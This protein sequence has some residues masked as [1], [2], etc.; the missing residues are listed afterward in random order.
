MSVKDLATSFVKRLVTKRISRRQAFKW[1]GVAV[2]SSLLPGMS[3][4]ARAQ[5]SREEGGVAPDE[6]SGLGAYL[7]KPVS[8]LVDLDP[9]S[10]PPGQQERHRIY[11]LLL[12]ALVHHYRNG[13]KRGRSGLYPWNENREPEAWKQDP[14]SND[15]EHLG[16][17]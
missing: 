7:D 9:I 12:M 6:F 15:G 10:I 11:L 13:N 4:S 3:G 17:D 16:G 14:S 8:E 1:T 5:D 2:G